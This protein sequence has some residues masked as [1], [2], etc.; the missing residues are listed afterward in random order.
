MNKTFGLLVGF[1]LLSQSVSLFAAPQA[2]DAK[3]FFETVQGDYEITGLVG[4]AKKPDGALANVFADTDVASLT[5]PYCLKKDGLCVPG[6]IDLTYADTRVDFEDLADGTVQFTIQ[7]K[8]A[9]VTSVYVWKQK[10]QDAS[11]YN[12]QAKPDGV[13][14]G[15]THLLKRV[16][17]P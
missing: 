10:G 14:A 15:L 2:M 11:F 5:F 7:S 17:N 8:V 1:F 9:G 16:A 3:D 12:A 4:N 6:Y 13:T